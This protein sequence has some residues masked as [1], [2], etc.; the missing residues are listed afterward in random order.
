MRR[1]INLDILRAIA[2]LMVLTAHIF[3]LQKPSWWNGWAIG[4]GWA[5]VDLF[6]V[7]SGFLISR[8][9]FSEYQ[10]TGRIAY[11]RFAFRRGMKI[12]PAFYAV[13]IIYLVWGFWRSHPHHWFLRPFAHDILFMDSYVEGTFGHFWSLAVEEHFYFLLPLMLFVMLRAAKP[14][15]S[16]PFRRLPALCLVVAVVVLGARVVTHFLLPEFSYFTHFFPT[17]LRIDSLLFGVLLGYWS[18]FHTDWFWAFIRK[19]H[20]LLTLLSLALI[21]PCVIFGQPGDVVAP[22]NPFLYTFGFTCIYLGFGLLMCLFLLVPVPATGLLGHLGRSM[23]GIGKYSYSIY[24]WHLPLIFIMQ[25]YSIMKAQSALILYYPVCIFLGIVMA[26]VIEEPSLRLRDY[27]SN[28]G[29]DA[30]L[31]TDVV[32]ADGAEV[33]VA[34]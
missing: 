1:N 33:R 29:A 19:H 34:L 13:S 11:G 28:R 24:L 32:E 6:F 16:D 3:F 22:P 25:K 30:G 18:Q 27:L 23:A 5:G 21:S 14:G 4:A 26:K 20:N 8:L 2:I 7:L 12:W 10:R 9:L 15:T 31:G 17:H